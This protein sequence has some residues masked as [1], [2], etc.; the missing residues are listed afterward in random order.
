MLV[1]KIRETLNIVIVK[2]KYQRMKFD[3]SFDIIETSSTNQLALYAPLIN[4]LC[5]TVVLNGIEIKSLF[6]CCGLSLIGEKKLTVIE[7]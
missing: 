2:D 4:L 1:E 3:I 5:Y 6:T 7:N